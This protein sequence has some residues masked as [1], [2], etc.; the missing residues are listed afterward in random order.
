MWS[1]GECEGVKASLHLA[2]WILIAHLPV[3]F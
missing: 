2:V 1:S 3:V